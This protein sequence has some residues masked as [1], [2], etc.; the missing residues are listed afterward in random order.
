MDLGNSL[1]WVGKMQHSQNKISHYRICLE[2]YIVNFMDVGI[3]NPIV[4]N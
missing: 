4:K 2:L 1:K 3:K